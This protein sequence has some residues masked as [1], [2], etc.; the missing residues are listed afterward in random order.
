MILY[1]LSLETTL[2]SATTVFDAS[3]VSLLNV[4]SS[5]ILVTFKDDEGITRVTLTLGA[6]ERIITRKEKTM[7]LEGSG[8][9]KAVAV[10]R[11]Q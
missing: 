1:P 4:S 10:I 3:F 8:D 11:Q 6:G 7:T 5:P 2:T 9:I